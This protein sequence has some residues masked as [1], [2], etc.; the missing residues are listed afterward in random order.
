MYCGH[1]APCPMGIDIATVTKFLNLVKAQGE[2]PETVREHYAVLE[3]TASE[4]V[5]CHACE[6]RCP[7]DVEVTENMRQA[8]N[9][10]GK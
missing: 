3:H 8:V 9:V 2:M 10:F 4:C 7:F 1:C 6:N 5:G